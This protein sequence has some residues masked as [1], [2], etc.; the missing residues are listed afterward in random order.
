M[1]LDVVDPLSVDTWQ[2]HAHKFVVL[3]FGFK[4][5]V[6]PVDRVVYYQSHVV[7]VHAAPSVDHVLI[8]AGLLIN[9]LQQLATLGEQDVTHTIEYGHLLMILVVARNMSSFMA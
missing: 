7:T 1:F 4:C 2:H 8:E 6:Q 3:L 9:I 5:S